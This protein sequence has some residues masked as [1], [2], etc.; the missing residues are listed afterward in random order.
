[1]HTFV[2]MN[3]PLLVQI[4]SGLLPDWHIAGLFSVGPF[5]KVFSK[6]LIQI[7]NFHSRKCIWKCC[8]QSEGRLSQSF[9]NYFD[10]SQ[11]HQWLRHMCFCLFPS[12]TGH[13][14]INDWEKCVFVSFQLMRIY[15]ETKGL[16]WF[17]NI[18]KGHSWMIHWDAST[19][20]ELTPWKKRAFILQM[21]YSNV[22]L[23][24]K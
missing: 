19:Y 14:I 1:M 11:H 23:E 5:E 4:Y 9:V 24:I 17:I 18:T 15:E 8:L 22:T 6:I 7:H 13:N 3:K 10:W 20:P 21:T 2:E 12:D 16:S